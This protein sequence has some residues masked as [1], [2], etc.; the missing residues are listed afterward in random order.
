MSGQETPK[1][2]P[3]ERLMTKKNGDDEISP[4][5][6]QEIKDAKTK[7]KI[8]DVTPP[9]AESKKRPLA[10]VNSRNAPKSQA[11]KKLCVATDILTKEQKRVLGA[12]MSGSSI[13]FTGRNSLSL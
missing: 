10:D 12:A 1:L 7:A 9:S 13:F 3:R 2:G 5:T 11:A 6:M 8:P 4:L